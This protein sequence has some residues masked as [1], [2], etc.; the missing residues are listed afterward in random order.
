MTGSAVSCY[1]GSNGSA[2]VS[3]SGVPSQ[4]LTYSWSTGANGT[5][6]AGLTAGTYS[7]LVKN[8]CTGCTST[9]YFTVNTPALISI[10][11]TVTN[12]DCFSGNDGSIA[13]NVTGGV[14]PYTYSWSPSGG[15]GPTANNLTANNYSLL[16]TDNKGCTKSKSFTV[17]QPLAPLNLTYTAENVDC[18]G[19]GSGSI[20]ISPFGGTPPYTYSWSP[21]GQPTQDIQ[22]LTSGSYLVSITD[23]KGCLRQQSIPITQPNQLTAAVDSVP[24]SC[25]GYSNGSVTVS[26]SGGVTPYS[27]LWNNSSFTFSQNSPTLVNVP[28]EV[29]SVEVTDANGCKVNQ[30]A[31]VG[32]PSQ[33]TVSN[34][35]LTHVKCFGES[36]GKIEL[37]VIGGTVTT[38]YSYQWSNSSGVIVGATSNILQNIPAGQYTV[39]ITDNNGCTKR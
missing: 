30:T 27:Y 18:F 37:A 24:V 2:Q 25:Y 8:T 4:Y 16:V 22:G 9:G 36:T 10:S 39:L 23:S 31:S 13:A 28:S 34:A 33:I 14:A 17:S 32:S 11:G 5:Q 26:P 35:T 12:V 20:D 3:V 19:N 21:G 7:V 38:G 1:G 29:Y 6:I 15:T